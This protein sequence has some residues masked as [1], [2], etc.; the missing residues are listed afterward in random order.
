MDAE[1]V[2]F[3]FELGETVKPRLSIA[4]VVFFEP[5]LADLLRIRERQSLRPVIDAFA[6]R[7]SR[8]A[9]PALQILEL[10]VAGGNFER[11][12]LITHG[13][14]LLDGD[15]RIPSDRCAGERSRIRASRRSQTAI[16]GTREP[17]ERISARGQRP[18]KAR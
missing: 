3:G 14:V 17:A 16:A 4:P 5:V 6:L 8:G 1:A 9:Q 18:R 2:D 12:N 10:V 7:P 13:C 15:N 11:N